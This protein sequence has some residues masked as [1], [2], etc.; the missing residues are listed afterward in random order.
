MTSAVKPP[1]SNSTL[2]PADT[3]GAAEENHSGD[4]DGRARA[5][6][7]LPDSS[8]IDPVHITDLRQLKSGVFIAQLGYATQLRERSNALIII[9]AVIAVTVGVFWLVSILGQSPSAHSWIASSI[10]LPVM[11]WMTRDTAEVHDRAW[12]KIRKLH[13]DLRLRACLHAS[14]LEELRLLEDV[15]FE[16]IIV[17]VD[18]VV[19]RIRYFFLIGVPLSILTSFAMQPLLPFRWTYFVGFFVFP[20]AG[21][22]FWIW[23]RLKPT[24]YRIIPG[25]LDMMRLRPFSRDGDG[26]ILR[27]WDLREAWIDCFDGLVLI[28]PSQSSD[29][30]H[31]IN[32]RHLSEPRQFVYALFHG[33]IS[34]HR[35]P[36]LPNDKLCND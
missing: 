29:D 27:E 7:I 12:N 16:P 36:D 32:A 24:Y 25:R 23:P 17:F 2:N 18:R 13:P 33:A 19:P 8:L 15:L 14:D 5:L 34:T 9:P 6:E 22:C 35:V 28:K 10:I 11:L 4:E 26:V 30:V 21:V 20:T 31:R 3:P 1:P